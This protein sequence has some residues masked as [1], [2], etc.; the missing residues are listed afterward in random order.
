MVKRL[1]VP[2]LVVLALTASL[3]PTSPAEAATSGQ[4][5]LQIDRLYRAY[6]LRDPDPAGL[7]YWT[8]RRNAGVPLSTVSAEFAR[9]AEFV[10]RYG[11]LGHRE[12][13]DLVYRNVLR[14]AADPAGA[15]YWSGLLSTGSTDRGTV[16]TGFSESIEFKVAQGHLDP[17]PVDRL[18][19]AFFL[20]SS[21]AQGRNYWLDQ[22]E[23]GASLRRIAD[24]FAAS[25]EFVARYG[26]LDDG[27]FVDLVYANVLGRAPDATG[28]AYWIGSSLEACRAAR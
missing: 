20:R 18:Y 23:R 13:V 26:A 11:T 24:V 5:S 4:H 10:S 8:G 16:M 15:D 12:F 9:S 21:D 25:P 1:L 7:S 14:R 3:Q 2:L 22:F 17:G 27:G 19:R 6:F 28:R